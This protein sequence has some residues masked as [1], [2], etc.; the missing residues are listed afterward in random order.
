MKSLG[1]A[2]SG[3]S[4]CASGPLLNLL[5]TQ[6]QTAP[7]PPAEVAEGQAHSPRQ[8]ER[9]PPRSSGAQT[10]GT[11]PCRAARPPQRSGGRGRPPPRYCWVHL[12]A[13]PGS[14]SIAQLDSK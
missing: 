12:D 1:S 14:L 11:A 5:G 9:F 2:Q 4:E 6:P 7:A 10:S 3:V 8:R 13:G